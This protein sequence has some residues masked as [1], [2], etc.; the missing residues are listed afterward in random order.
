M[1]NIQLVLKSISLLQK[2]SRHFLKQTRCFT[3]APMYG[4]YSNS[5]TMINGT[6]T[7]VLRSTEKL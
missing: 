4:I 6:L 2:F 3:A 7:A 1:M 5:L